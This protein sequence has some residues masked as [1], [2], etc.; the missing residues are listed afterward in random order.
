M[1]T[2]LCLAPLLAAASLG[3]QQAFPL[4]VSAAPGSTNATENTAPFLIPARMTQTL[5]TNYNTLLGQG[6]PAS[7]LNWDMSTFDASGRFIFTPAEVSARGGGVFRYDTRTGSLTVLIHGNDTGVRTANPASWNPQ[8]DDYSRCDPCTLT[9]WNTILWG[10]ETTGGRLFE[11]TNPL[12]ATGPYTVRWLT[13]IPA[14]AHEGLRL[15]AQGSLYFVDEDNSGCIYK[16]VPTVAG[17]LSAGQTFVL[18]VDGY[19]ADANAR[20]NESWNS[21]SNRLTNRFGAA[22]WV[23]LTG[24]NGQQITVTNPFVYVTANSGR[25]AADEVMGTPYGR[26]EDMD[27]NTLAD[28]HQCIYVSITSENRVISIELTGSTTAI[29]REFVNYDTIN[30]ATGTDV[31]PLQNDPYTNPGGGTVFVTPDN[32]AVDAFGS[33]YLVEDDEPNGGDIWKAIDADK[34]GVAEAI[35]IFLS[36][37]VGG[38]E[39]TGLFFDPSNPYSCIVNVQHPTS[40]NNA[41]W[42][43]DTRPYAGS[44]ADL[45]LASGVNRTASSGPGEFVKNARGG[46]VI[47]LHIA[48]PSHTFDNAPYAVLMQPTITPPV[49]FLPPLWVSPLSPIVVVNGGFAGGFQFVLPAGGTTFSLRAPAG[50]TGINVIAQ[51]LAVTQFGA[52]IATDAHEILF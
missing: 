52:L 46:D 17:D 30:L 9:P 25:L 45:V 33:V 39:P 41:T 44:D 8:N 34:D 43:I 13:S 26:P 42:R 16:F 28:G 7:M 24:V 35:G 6:L 11:I 31:N 38:S 37:G 4:P 50:L 1:R 23:A 12:D 21:T 36:L 49:R 27:F 18:S 20:P 5:V 32:I 10:E 40:G 19:A 48:S 2:N 15:D 3:A 14:V 29:V 51:G 47:D 22:H